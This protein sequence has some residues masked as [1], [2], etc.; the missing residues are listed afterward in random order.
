MAQVV[1]SI[2]LPPVHLVL[3][4]SALGVG[5]NWASANP[6][7]VRSV[8]L[9]DA[10][11]ESAAF[12]ARLIGVPVLG[13]ILLGS[14]AVFAGLIKLPVQVIWSNNW[15]DLW[16]DEG[17]RVAAAVPR[18]KLGSHSGGRWPQEDAA[19]VIAKM[20]AQFVLALPKSVKQDIKAPVPE[21]I[22]RIF[23]EAKANGQ[24]DDNHHHEHD[25]EHTT[26]YMSMYG[27]DQS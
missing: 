13:R 12:P 11:A 2:A 8:T 19:D 5:A 20:I 14:R 22:Q 4:D 27:L 9:V 25:D 6:S 3:H 17:R 16:I 7:S 26:G 1:D 18:A 10:A 24:L 15:S 23:D 21:H